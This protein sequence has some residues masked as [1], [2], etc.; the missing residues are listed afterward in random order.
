MTIDTR[1][2]LI[3]ALGNDHDKILWDKA[4]IASMISGQMASLWKATGLPAAG[5]NPAAAALCTSALLGAIA[6]TN[7]V[8]PAVGY[9]GWHS[10]MTG[11]A[12]SNL[13]IHDRL[14]HMG[15]LVGNVVTAQNANI[16]LATLTL[17]ANRLGAADYSDVSWW[18]EWYTATGA[19][20]SNVTV[21]VTFSDGSTGNLAAIAVGGTAV[22][23]SRIFKLITNH[24]SGLDI[25][26]VNTVTLS[27]STGTAGS[28]GITATRHR[29]MMSTGATANVAANFDYA[30]LG[31][32]K[33]QN[34]ACLFGIMM[35]TATSTGTV[36]GYGKILH[37]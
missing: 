20:A 3:S 33:I 16:D 23:A 35:C 8:A 29:T 28:F 1:D 14:A 25:K 32:P 4:S 26:G 31:M 7:Q 6:Y 9:I 13:E 22:A 18:L 36:K 21:N 19:T 37:G 27:A 12:N 30:Q 24:A 17:P 11:N 2:A 10:L 5:A 34:D 15:G